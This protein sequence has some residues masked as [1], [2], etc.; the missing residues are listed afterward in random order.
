MMDSTISANTL[1]APAG[2]NGAFYEQVSTSVD[3]VPSGS[4][5]GDVPAS[6]SSAAPPPPSGSA[7]P[8]QPPQPPAGT[9]G[10][11]S[12]QEL[13]LGSATA[14]AATGPAAQFNSKALEVGSQASGA[15]ASS[16]D[17]A[18]TVTNP[19]K[20]GE[21]MSAYVTYEV[22]TKTS[23]SQYQFGQLSVSRRFRDFDWLHTQLVNK[24]PGAIVPA[25]LEKQDLKNA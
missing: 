10:E 21:G 7:A 14:A 12:F 6:S 25:L 16:P 22:T 5:V 11:Q 3:G 1:A 8:P 15:R 20:Q 19:S 13:D 2:G 9:F 24:Y 23:L 18:V 17:L 4:G